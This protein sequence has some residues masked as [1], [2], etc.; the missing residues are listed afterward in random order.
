MI[1]TILAVVTEPTHLSLA[2]E[3]VIAAYLAYVHRDI[4]A[5]RRAVSTCPVCTKRSKSPLLFL[6]PAILLGMLIASL[7]LLSGCVNYR[8]TSPSGDTTR[9]NACL[10][11]GNASAVKSVTT[12]TNGY[13]RTVGLGKV[14]AGTE[15]EKL[16]PLVESAVRGGVSAFMQ[17]AAPGSARAP[18][19]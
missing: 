8:H 17:S 2:G 7:L 5:I 4:I 19:P 14:S 9:F 13:N 12:D 6:T 11:W 1:E 18:A 3:A 10:M 15:T 16:A